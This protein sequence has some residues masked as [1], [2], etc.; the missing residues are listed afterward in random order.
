[1]TSTLLTHLQ[2]V[3]EAVTS[4]QVNRT[5]HEN[6]QTAVDREVHQDHYHTSVQ[7]IAHKD[8]LPEK[9]SH[10]V[11]DVEH[12]HI[13]H[14]NEDHVEERLAQEAAQFKNT[15]TM[16]HTQH[17][18]SAAPT[19]GGEHVHHHVHETIQPVINKETVQPHVVHTTI[20]VHEVHQNEAK[21]H[22]ASTLPAVTMDQFKSQGGHIGGRGER[23]DAFSGEPKAVGGT[24]GGHGASGTTSLTEQ[25]S[26]HGTTGQG[27]TGNHGTTG[28][29]GLTGTHDTH[30][31]H[32]TGMGSTGTSTTTHTKPSLMDKLNPMKDSDGDGKKGIM[33]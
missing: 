20:P 21:H 12:K 7:P 3:N 11:A 33:K 6:V 10:Q 28:Q 2:R 19:L 18:T 24:L 13:K 16:G 29:H 26:R 22:T 25:E 4:E 8:V 27:L 17:T 32:G 14:G 31:T 15:Q 30:G 23:T 9:H 5:H 1:M